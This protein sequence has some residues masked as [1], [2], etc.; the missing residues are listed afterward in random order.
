MDEP[1]LLI[2]DNNVMLASCDL[3]SALQ[4]MRSTE[5]GATTLWQA[6]KANLCLAFIRLLA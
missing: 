5:I 3:R 2:V 1:L 6:R 4:D